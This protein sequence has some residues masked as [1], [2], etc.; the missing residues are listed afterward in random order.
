MKVSLGFERLIRLKEINIYDFSDGDEQILN[1][2]GWGELKEI[3]SI[4]LSIKCKVDAGKIPRGGKLIRLQVVR[5]EL[6]N[7]EKLLDI[8]TLKELDIISTN[9][10]ADVIKQLKENGVEVN[11]Y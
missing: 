8:T 7:V 5:G 3:E 4:Q 10:P 1:M 2:D 6:F 11:L 9:I